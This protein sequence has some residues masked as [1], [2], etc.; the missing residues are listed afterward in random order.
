METFLNALF[1][2]DGSG[3]LA[4]FTLPSRRTHFFEVGADGW[5]DAVRQRAQ[6][7]RDQ[8]IYFG[9]GLLEGRPRDRSSRGTEGEVVSIPGLWLDVD[10]A[11]DGHKASNLPPTFEEALDLI[12]EFPF[13]PTLIVYSGGGLHAYWL[14][15][16]PWR[17]D[18]D[19]RERLWMAKL[20]EK[21]QRH[22]QAIANFHGWHVDPTYDLARIMRLPGTV[23]QKYG[24]EVEI[25]EFEDVNR[26]SPDDIGEWLA[27]FAMEPTQA[28]TGGELWE[29]D[30]SIP[31]KTLEG[32]GG[33]NNRLKMIVAA[34]LDRGESL[35]QTVFECLRYDES[36]HSPPLFSDPT[37]FRST[38]AYTNALRF[39]SNVAESINRSRTRQGEEPQRF[40]F[41]VHE[42]SPEL[43]QSE[44]EVLFHDFGAIYQDDTPEPPDLVGGGLLGPG[45]F[46]LVAG[47]PK[48]MKSLFCQ[49]M[50]ISCATGQPFLGRFRVAR[51]LRCAFVN[52]EMS[53]RVLRRR[54]QKLEPDPFCLKKLARNLVITERFHLTLD[55]AG[56][57]RMVDLL[58]AMFPEEPPDVILVDPLVNIFPGDTEN[59]NQAMMAFLQRLESVRAAVNPE[60][61][62][63]LVHHTSKVSRRDLQDDPFNAIRGASALRGHYSSGIMI[64]QESEESTER[65]VFYNIRIDESPEPMSVRYDENTFTESVGEHRIAG[66]SQ[67]ARYDAEAKRKKNAIVVELERLAQ[68]EGRMLTG[69]QFAEVY[70]NQKGLGSD[71]SIQRKISEL[72][73]KGWIAY[74]DGYDFPHL[75]FPHPNSSGFLVTEG[76]RLLE[77]DP[78][79]GEVGDFLEVEPTH[80]KHPD[81]GAVVEFSGWEYHDE[82]DPTFSGRGGWE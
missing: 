50:L 61:G 19:E 73:S 43:G 81:T 71:R 37:E 3:T 25:V 40:T 45:E 30:T 48:S 32:A 15:H 77:V 10:V 59:D 14:F 29:G 33:R 16:E 78:E 75:P 67:G 66:R 58:G 27:D 23:N 51:E 82:E 36:E 11:G 49:D 35:E 62:L 39:V 46:L 65:R 34:C 47:P 22:F 26:Y 54:I 1:G 31:K 55:D 8:N 53:Y 68:E 5:L 28:D 20:S 38:H 13:P 80:K 69:R 42:H 60:A 7:S 63:V 56:A 57:Q 44:G 21:F 18:E 64:A 72:T 24:R 9:V 2:S 74:S 52:L 41:Q 6:R 70:A 4:L 76:M 12:H 17:F 79:T